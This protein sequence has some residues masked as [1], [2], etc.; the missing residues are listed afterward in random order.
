MVHGIVVSLEHI[1]INDKSQYHSLLWQMQKQG[2]EII[3]IHKYMQNFLLLPLS[4]EYQS[5]QT[6]SNQSK[7]HFSTPYPTNF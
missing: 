1:I 3:H 6:K 7:T 5:N 4:F 2:T